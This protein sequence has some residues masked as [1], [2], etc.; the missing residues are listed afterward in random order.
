M[1][2]PVRLA[3]RVRRSD[4][5]T[6]TWTLAEGG[7]GRRWREVVADGRSVRW[8]LLY[9]TDPVGRFSHLELATPSG[10]ATLHPETDGTLHGNVVTE[11]GVRHVVAFAVP[12]GA[13][14]LVQ[15]SFISGAVIARDREPGAPAVVLD[16]VTL[17]LAT[18]PLV[19]A[20]LVAVDVTG[21][22][23][24]AAGER[25]PLED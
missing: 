14:M 24:D 21:A 16:P 25:W 20:D 13:A 10:L 3:G 22:P 6:V 8:S 9:E 19:E 5:S 23:L 7:K 15:G 1:S 4:G 18:R 12:N 2:Q 11:A 17:Q